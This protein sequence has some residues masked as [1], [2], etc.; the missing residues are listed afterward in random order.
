VAA[1]K[2]TMTNQKEQV[3][4]AGQAELLLP[5]ETRPAAEG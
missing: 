1:V 5:T 2:V 4:A 3:M